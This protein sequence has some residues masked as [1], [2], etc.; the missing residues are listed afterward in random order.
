MLDVYKYHSNPS[1]LAGYADPWRPVV[2]KL[3]RALLTINYFR[4]EE[5]E[6]EPLR[7]VPVS[8]GDHLVIQDEN[9]GKRLG[10]ITRE[11]KYCVMYHG[12]EECSRVKSDDITGEVITEYIHI[13]SGVWG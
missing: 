11:G 6:D 1:E 5:E 9:T 10:R 13:L 2:L 8:E 4:V 7:Y 3:V 12:N